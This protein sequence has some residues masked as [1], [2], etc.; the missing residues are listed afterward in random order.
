MY[1]LSARKIDKI[2]SKL[3]YT[4]CERQKYLASYITSMKGLFRFTCSIGK[5]FFFIKNGDK[6]RGLRSLAS[7]TSAGPDAY[8]LLEK[9]CH[10]SVAS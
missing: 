8:I 9:Y 1:R 3:M 2:I 10:T 4:Q 5:T 7:F 6:Q